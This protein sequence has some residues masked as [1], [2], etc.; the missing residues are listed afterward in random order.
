MWNATVEKITLESPTQLVFFFFQSFF[1]WWKELQRGRNRNRKKMNAFSLSFFFSYSTFCLSVVRVFGGVK[2]NGENPLFFFT[3]P[4]KIPT[5]RWYP[6]LSCLREPKRERTGSSRVCMS[7]PSTHS[8]IPF[9]GHRQCQK[10]FHYFAF[11]F[12]SNEFLFVFL[13]VSTSKPNYMHMYMYIYYT[14]TL[15]CHIIISW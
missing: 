10:S 3:P 9:Y 5:R 8:L 11:S 2:G 15:A 12:D 4:V 7:M 1:F 13:K 14:F 6:V